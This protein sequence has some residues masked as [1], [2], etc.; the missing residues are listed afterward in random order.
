MGSV[1]KFH[2]E[3]YGGERM[4]FYHLHKTCGFYSKPFLRVNQFY[5]TLY[6]KKKEGL[7]EKWMNS[8]KDGVKDMDEILLP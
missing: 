1:G 7:G 8:M 3:I 5:L 6:Y 2:V 4:V